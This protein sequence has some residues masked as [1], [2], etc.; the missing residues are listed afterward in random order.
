[1]KI[2]LFR[3]F[4]GVITNERFYVAGEYE[5]GGVMPLAHAQALV[6]DRRGE[7]I[8]EPPPKPARA[9]KPKRSRKASK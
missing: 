9:A 4:R 3:D 1:M 8:D 6:D 2:K 7:W 5:V